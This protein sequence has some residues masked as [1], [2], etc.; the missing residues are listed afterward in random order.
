MK[1]LGANGLAL[2]MTDT[3]TGSPSTTSGSARIAAKKSVVKTFQTLIHTVTDVASRCWGDNDL[4]TL[5]IGE[6]IVNSATKVL[7]DR[8]DFIDLIREELGKDAAEYL[9]D[10]V[11]DTYADGYQDGYSNGYGDGLHDGHLEE[12]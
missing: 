1:M 9:I 10:L 12:I 4:R 3:P 2:S 7:F 11:D 8:Q 5:Y 6:N